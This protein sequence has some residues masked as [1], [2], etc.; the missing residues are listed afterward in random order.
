MKGEIAVMHRMMYLDDPCITVLLKQDIVTA[1]K[2][3]LRRLCFYRCLSV[4]RGAIHGCG[5]ACVVAG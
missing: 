4:H 5:G 3:S 2:R 1:R